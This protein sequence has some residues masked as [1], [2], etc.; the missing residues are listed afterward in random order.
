MVTE[1][2]CVRTA[3]CWSVLEQ[4]AHKVSAH[5]SGGGP[6]ASV[7][8]VPPTFRDLDLGSGQSVEDGRS[9]VKEAGDPGLNHWRTEASS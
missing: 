4:G 5:V 2:T 7:T 6:G 9:N 3:D 8:C 1:K